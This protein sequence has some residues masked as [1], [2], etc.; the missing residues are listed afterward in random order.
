MFDF[1]RKKKPPV[2]EDR[3]IPEPLNSRYN[4]ANEKFSITHARIQH[5]LAKEK[6]EA[7]DLEWIE[8]SLEDTEKALK[9]MVDA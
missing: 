9:K 7:S 1:L 3:K 5:V 2:S 8:E 6:I 4:A